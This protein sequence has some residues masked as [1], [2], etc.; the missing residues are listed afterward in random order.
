MSENPIDQLKSR[1][2]GS[3]VSCGLSGEASAVAVTGL[4]DLF[5]SVHPQIQLVD[6]LDTGHW[7]DWL[8]HRADACE[9]VDVAVLLRRI[10]RAG[11]VDATPCL[12][13]FIALL[14]HLK[15]RG[16]FG[17]IV[18]RLVALP[19]AETFWL[20]SSADEAVLLDAERSWFGDPAEGYR[21]A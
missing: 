9:A 1:L 3:L 8:Q 11:S 21:V 7:L 14:R 15:I 10:S 18:E 6:A 12:S 5:G 20:P 17:D 13:E 16:S 19:S 2:T 4:G